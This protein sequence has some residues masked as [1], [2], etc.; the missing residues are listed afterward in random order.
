MSKWNHLPR[1]TSRSHYWS[2]R[3]NLHKLFKSILRETAKLN[4]CALNAI[5]C[6]KPWNASTRTDDSRWVRHR[7]DVGIYTDGYES[8]GV[9]SWWDL[10]RWLRTYIIYSRMD[11][12][13]DSSANTYLKLD[14]HNRAVFSKWWTG[15]EKNLCVPLNICL[16]NQFKYAVL[17]EWFQLFTERVI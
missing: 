17:M 9:M 3:A 11:P 14:W 12:V 5:W 4:F 7:R 1:T 16:C 10:S 6:A 2:N 15:I 8:H 13:N